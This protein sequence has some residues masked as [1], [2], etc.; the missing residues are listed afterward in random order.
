MSV[1]G[2]VTGTRSLRRRP[3]IAADAT[4]VVAMV[5]VVAVQVVVGLDSLLVRPLWEDEAFNLTVPRNLV[6][7]LGYTS[8][9]VLSGSELMPFD[10]RI[11]TGPA[12]LL[13]VA[14]LLGLGVDPALAA[15]LVPLAFYLA[16]LLGAWLLGR[17]IAGRWGGLLAVALPLC[18]NGASTIS[19]IQGPADL[20]G[21][22]P[23]AT[24]LVWAMV[25][26]R[27][28]VWLAGLLVGL[29]ISTKFVSL[30]AVPAFVCGVIVL[31][32]GL[33]WSRRIVAVVVAALWAAVP[34]V[35]Y[36]LVAAISLGREGYLDHVRRMR[37]FVLT[38]G[39]D[40]VTTGPLDKL[41]AWGA[42]WYVPWTVVVLVIVVL[43]V[44]AVA[45]VR[46]RRRRGPTGGRDADD[47]IGDF[48]PRVLAALLTIAGVGAVTFAVWWVFSTNTPVWVRHPAPAVYAFGPVL[49]AFAVRAIVMLTRS[50][51][52][53]DRV[54]AVAASIVVGATVVVQMGVHALQPPPLYET[55]DEQRQVAEE[56]RDLGNDW[57]AVQWGAPLSVTVLSGAR[58]GAW[59]DDHVVAGL[60]RVTWSDQAS[61][62]TEVMLLT[63]HYLVC[64]APLT[65]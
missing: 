33:S 61:R 27:R 11:S 34:T 30:I 4:F 1:D 13:P 38:T 14:A 58:V 23:A 12:V 44:V 25:A 22:I 31:L 65:Q 54:V 42:T 2:A 18:F 32:S 3:G 5:A 6:L 35:V 51:H 48:S 19:P 24:F 9:G 55:L 59:H 64:A 17:G 63:D 60:P 39:Q 7:G 43:L 49:A 57:Y 50:A 47:R 45:V 37:H 41:V 29:A 15:R 16:L 62:C 46:L 21:E 26:L 28:R 36:E 56:I 8:D 40:A 53:G 52:R 20:L 10:P